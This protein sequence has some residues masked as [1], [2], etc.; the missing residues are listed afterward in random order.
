MNT[1]R[2]ALQKKL[3]MSLPLSLAI[4]SDESGWRVGGSKNQLCGC[5]RK[6]ER[7]REIDRKGVREL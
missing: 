2:L 4:H 3:Q 7:E 5:L 6:R 1:R